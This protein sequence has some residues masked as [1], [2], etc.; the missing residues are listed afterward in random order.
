MKKRI[1][2]ITP[3]I[4][5]FMIFQNTLKSQDYIP[6]PENNATWTE[7][8][9]IYEGNPPQVWTSLYITET[10]T[11]L[12]DKAYKNIYEYYLNPNNFDTIRELYA[13][14][15]QDTSEKKVFIIRHY[16]SE[17]TERLLLDFNADVGDTLILDAYYWDIDPIN[18]DSTFIL[19]SISEIVLSNNQTHRVQYLSNHNESLPVSQTIIEGVGSI[20]NPFGPATDLVNK[21]H[22]KSEFCCPDQLLCLTVNG[23]NIY[24]SNDESDCLELSVWTSAITAYQKATVYFYPNPIDDICHIQINDEYAQ[25]KRLEIIDLWGRK[26]LYRKFYQNDFTIDLSKLESGTYFALIWCNNNPIINK[27]IITH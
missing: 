22:G 16:F 9:A 12:L 20:F 24:T 17:N 10:D 6:F 7:Q 4:A 25:E 8:N 2:K 21:N 18:T 15:R 23:E 27:I 13:S 26:V 5:L 19:D 14:I 1:L 11:L 3:V